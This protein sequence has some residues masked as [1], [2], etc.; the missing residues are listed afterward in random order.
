MGKSKKAHEHVY[1]KGGTGL[2]AAHTHVS[3]TIE[4]KLERPTVFEMAVSNIRV[5]LETVRALLADPPDQWTREKA[6]AGLGSVKTLLTKALVDL[7]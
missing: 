7:Q 3:H 5:A 4:A 1:G 6:V 2:T